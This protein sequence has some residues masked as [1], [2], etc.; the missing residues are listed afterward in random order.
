MSY[1]YA[2]VL[3]CPH[4]GYTANGKA[5][6]PSCADECFCPECGEKFYYEDSDDED[7]EEE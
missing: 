7:A 6:D 4:C 2:Y 3:T 1:L 5:F